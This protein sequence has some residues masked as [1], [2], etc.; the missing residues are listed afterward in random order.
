MQRGLF[1]VNNIE[2]EYFQ[3]KFYLNHYN[4]LPSPKNSSR[5]LFIFH[6]YNAENIPHEGGKKERKTLEFKQDQKDL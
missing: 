1:K 3:F 4:R 2:L 6:G 5:E